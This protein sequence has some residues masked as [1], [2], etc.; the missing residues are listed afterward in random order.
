MTTGNYLKTCTWI[1]TIIF[2][3]CFSIQA[4]I[5]QEIIV[6]ASKPAADIKPTMWGVF[7]EDINF[8]ADGGIYAE[9]VKNRSFEFSLP[10]MGWKQV[11]LSGN[12]RILPTFYSPANPVNPHY[13]EAVVDAPAGS[14]GITNE[15]FR[16]MGIKKDETYNFS[17]Y[18]RTA[19]NSNLKMKLELLGSTGTVLASSEVTGL[20]DTWKRCTASLNATAT[21]PKAQLRILWSGKGT[22]DIDMVSLF[23][24]TTWKNRPG[25]LRDDLVQLIADLK[26]GFLRFPGGCIVEGRD[27]ANRYQ[28]KTTVG[29]VDERKV[30]MN[31]WNV[32]IANRQAPDYYQTFGLGFYEY[33]QLAEDIGAEPLPILNC[34]MS[35]QFNAGEVVPL[36]DL[37]PY[38][39]DALDLIEF[40][41]GGIATKWGKLRSTMGHAKPFN[42]KYIGVGNEQWDV[43]YIE[44]Y[45]EFEKAIKAKFPD[46]KII[47]GSGPSDSGPLFEYAWSELKKLSPALIDEHYYKP[48][49]W[50][51][52]NAGRYDSY[53]RKGIKVFAG[54]YAAHGKEADTAE[55]RNSWYSA[56]A[57]A[58]F[59]TGLERNA[60]IVNMASYAPLLAHV[61]AWQWRPDLIW[62]DNLNAIGSPNYYVQKIFS[63]YKGTQV[64]PALSKGKPVIGQ[65]SLYA[66]ASFDRLAGK[67]YI[68]LVNVSGLPKYSL[69]NI[70]GPSFGTDGVWIT[71]KS[72]GLYD[73]N[74]MSDPKHIFPTGRQVPITGNK[75]EITMSPYSVNVLVVTIKK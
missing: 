10:M 66:S 61:D 60:D 4:L 65:D 24:S 22:I 16:G 36:S 73:F 51:L 17:V 62:F 43:Q 46:I 35:C 54:E 1:M 63:N 18:A 45:K 58:A 19:P 56:L 27:L 39:Q 44:R 2:L 5:A 70:Q 67:A 29:P 59:M 55:S 34:G 41:N 57:E 28:W 38:I 72:E 32:E 30:I 40:A 8:A 31:R 20:S 23:P 48:P 25:G 47:S 52:Q 14:F 13:L 37:N 74:S 50:F 15:G 21:D 53:D 33:F 69:V 7:F 12:G 9:L 6:Q 71:L 26:P 68:K 42:L 75:V 11:N 3:F 49:E 64:I